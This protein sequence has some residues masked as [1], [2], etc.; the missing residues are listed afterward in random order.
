M[1]P[2]KERLQLTFRPDRPQRMR[3]LIDRFRSLWFF[4]VY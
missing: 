2:G 3:E 1:T 4:C